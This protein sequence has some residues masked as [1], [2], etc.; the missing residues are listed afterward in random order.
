EQGDFGVAVEILSRVVSKRETLLG[1]KDKETIW[2]KCILARAFRGQGKYNDALEDAELLAT[3]ALEKRKSILG[4][5]HP[6]T[7]RITCVLARIYRLQGRVG[8]FER[9]GTFVLEKMKKSLGLY[10]PD[11][12]KAMQDLVMQPNGLKHKFPISRSKGTTFSLAS[13]KG[14]RK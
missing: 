10:D 14:V 11:T 8:L 5:E 2:A 3:V 1:T 6:D 7:L 9:T 13:L 4:D 12:I